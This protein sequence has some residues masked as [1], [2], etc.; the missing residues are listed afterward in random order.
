DFDFDKELD[1]LLDNDPEYQAREKELD[2][3]AGKA[4]Q[5][6]RAEEKAKPGSSGHHE[7][8][9]DMPSGFYRDKDG[10]VRLKMTNTVLFS[11]PT[12]RLYRA[13]GNLV[14]VTSQAGKQVDVVLSPRDIGAY[15]GR[16]RLQG[17]NCFYNPA[18]GDKLV[19]GF[20]TTVA[21]GLG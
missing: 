12:T 13:G 10:F 15:S 18:A 16:A 1:A 19:N 20:L 21:V 5:Q 9:D 14:V 3:L 7:Y 4:K 11:V 17:A 6:A 8:Q 2:A